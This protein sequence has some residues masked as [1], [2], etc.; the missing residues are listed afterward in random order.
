MSRPVAAQEPGLPQRL[1]SV[2]R[3]RARP[4]LFLG[5]LL[6]LT[7]GIVSAVPAP[8]A[9]FDTGA[10]KLLLRL[11]PAGLSGLAALWPLLVPVWLTGLGALL[12]VLA[13]PGSRP[14]WRLL[15][16]AAILFLSW[17]AFFGT[18][19][20][21]ISRVVVLSWTALFWS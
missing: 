17:A 13:T 7:L 21:A 11:V 15:L 2:T 3:R 16:V 8:E 20:L 19:I 12:A 18:I 9:Y 4:W 14:G 5:A 1:G 10:W 6:T